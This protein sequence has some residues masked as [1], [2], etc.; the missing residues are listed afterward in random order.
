MPDRA[1]PAR[2]L[3]TRARAGQQGP[4]SEFIA[5]LWHFSRPRAGRSAAGADCAGSAGRGVFV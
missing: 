1:R 5:G 2:P 4:G 3:D